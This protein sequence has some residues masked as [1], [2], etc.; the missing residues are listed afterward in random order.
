[1][2]GETVTMS[3]TLDGEDLG[4]AFT[5]PKA[6]LNGEP[7]FPHILTKNSSFSCNFGQD[8]PW[9]PPSDNS[10]SLI[11]KL[12]VDQDLV[13]G[14]KRPASK[15]ECEVIMMVGVPA[16][17]KTHWVEKYVVENKQKHYTVLGTNNLIDKMKVCY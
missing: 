5:V 8:E 9:F 16:C 14:L 2:S 3:Y 17:G 1:M 11:G 12:S 6:E 13:Q 7:L 4:V 10:F 15:E